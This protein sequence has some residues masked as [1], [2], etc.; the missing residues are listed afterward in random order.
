MGHKT[1]LEKHYERYQEEDFERFPEYQKAIPFLTV[2][3]EEGM[4]LENERLKEEKSELE[5]NAEEILLQKDEI[6]RQGQ[7]INYL[8]DEIKKFQKSYTN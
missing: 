1:G 2:S 6:T 4:R 8:L 5:K 3:D 7:S